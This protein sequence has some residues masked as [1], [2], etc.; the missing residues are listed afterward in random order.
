MVGASNPAT[1]LSTVVLPQPEG[2]RKETNSPF[3]MVRSKS[4]TTRVG[5]KAF[6]RCERS[7]KPMRYRLTVV[8]FENRVKSWISPMQAQVMTKAITA[9]AEGS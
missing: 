9:S 7:R 4:F 2:P 6:S 1:I 8:S 5:P 3:S